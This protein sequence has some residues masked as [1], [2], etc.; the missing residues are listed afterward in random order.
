MHVSRPTSSSAEA[1][2]AYV[3]ESPALLRHFWSISIG[4]RWCC[5]L[6]LFSIVFLRSWYS[7]PN[8]TPTSI[9]WSPSSRPIFMRTWSPSIFPGR[10]TFGLFGL[11]AGRSLPRFQPDC[12]VSS[13]LVTGLGSLFPFS[14]LSVSLPEAFC[15][16]A[17][18]KSWLLMIK[19]KNLSGN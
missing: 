4:L 1:S 14:L 13:V 3:K 8:A 15:A 18:I 9:H 7:I 6:G 12:V 16:P 5:I 19:Y 10:I 2:V 11:L 17:V